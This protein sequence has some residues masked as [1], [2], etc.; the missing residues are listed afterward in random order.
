MIIFKIRVFNLSDID[1]DIGNHAIQRKKWVFSLFE[2]N[3]PKKWKNIQFLC[4]YVMLTKNLKNACKIFFLEIFCLRKKSICGW[5]KKKFWGIF[6]I[7][8]KFFVVAIKKMLVIQFSFKKIALSPFFQKKNIFFSSP[9]CSI[10][11]K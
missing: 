3:F 1:Q 8:W 10:W 5:R 9:D 2:K 6:N 11:F 4:I 7:T